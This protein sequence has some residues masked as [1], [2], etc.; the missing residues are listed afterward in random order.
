M[1]SF[2]RFGGDLDSATKAILDK[3][4]RNVEVLKQSQNNP[5]PVEEQIA[6]IYLSSN[7]LLKDVPVEKVNLFEQL[8][9]QEMRSSYR[10]VLNALRDGLLKEEDMKTMQ[11][12]AQKIINGL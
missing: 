1:E 9:L 10:S 5:Y 4:A 2:L 11:D 12:L 6:I 3:G 7:A 8:F